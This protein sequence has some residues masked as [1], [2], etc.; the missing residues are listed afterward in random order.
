MIIDYAITLPWPDKKLSPNARIHWSARAKKSKEQRAA[1][2]IKTKEVMG[3]FKPVIKSK[4]SLK[5]EFYPPDKRRRDGDNANASMKSAYDGIADALGVDDNLFIIN[6]E[7]K[8]QTLNA[9]IIFI[10]FE[11]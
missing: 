5:V 4:V 8:E 6:Y 11:I 1:S 3:G 7:M 2:F 10:S 9:V